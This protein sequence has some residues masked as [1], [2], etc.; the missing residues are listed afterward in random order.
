L[1]DGA[2]TF[3]LIDDYGTTAPNEIDR[4]GRDERVLG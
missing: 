3:T 4:H 2:P 1:T